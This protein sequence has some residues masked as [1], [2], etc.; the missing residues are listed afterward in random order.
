ML[1]RLARA[2]ASFDWW[3]GRTSRE[4]DLA[5]AGFD[6]RLYAL[7]LL[8]DAVERFGVLLEFPRVIWCHATSMIPN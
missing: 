4:S 8:D 5:E 3:R 6:F 2:L 1:S 7:S